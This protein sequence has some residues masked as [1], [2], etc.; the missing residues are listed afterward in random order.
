MFIVLE[1]LDGAGKSTQIRML[2]QLLAERG[3]ESEYVHFPRFDAP[4]YGELIAR[5]LRGEFGGVNEV[6]PY[7]VALLFAGDR[8]AAGPQ[9]R[10]WIAEG[11]AVVLDRYV[12][13]NVGFQCAKLPA[14]ER[15]DRL[16]QWIL[17]LEFGY[18]DLPRPDLSL[19]LDVPF[20]FTERKLTEVREGDDRD[21]LQGSRDI[22]EDALDLQRRVREVYL[23]PR[24]R[25]IRCVWSIAAIR[26]GRWVRPNIIS[27]NTGRAGPD[28]RRAMRKTRTFKIAAN[29]CRLILACTFIVSG[30]T[31]VIDPWGTALKVNEYLSIYGLDYLQPGAMVFSIWLCGA[32]L[33]MGCML[34]FK[35][36]IRLISIFAVLSMVFFTLLTLLSATLI[37]VEDCGCFG[38]ALKLT[39]WE[40][41]VK[42]VVLLPMAFVVWWRYRPDKI[43]AFKPLEIVLTCTFFF[44]AMY[45]GYYCYIHL[46]LVDFLPYKV[47]VNIREAM[48]APVVEP[49]ESETVL[50][51]R[52]RR[53]GRERE[54]SLE[55][56]EW[57]DAENGS[58]STPAPRAKS[59]P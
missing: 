38:E 55:D 27:K 29:V 7:L 16:A 50:V 24:R 3:V 54:F 6:D 39:P 53:T 30:F 2:R 58:G 5:F 34:L 9:I 26:R 21:Y 4:V 57:Q 41:F 20:A 11:K 1:G 32:E 15:R 44:L 56:T 35:V 18:N 46:P 13:S 31:K 42:N 12:Y 8:A 36:R 48:Q 14:G 49:G 17:D 22:H 23:A 37:P 10:A 25:T 43:F 40:T 59:R 45:L 28:T 52:N 19:F 51:Y 33:M 47:G